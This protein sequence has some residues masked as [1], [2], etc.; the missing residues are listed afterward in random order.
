MTAGCT[1]SST[2]IHTW[3]SGGSAVVLDPEHSPKHCTRSRGGADDAVRGPLGSHAGRAGHVAH[4]RAG[5][6][7]SRGRLPVGL[8]QRQQGDPN[9]EAANQL[10]RD[11]MADLE[12]ALRAIA[13]AARC[14]DTRA[15]S[16]LFAGSIRGAHLG[17]PSEQSPDYLDGWDAP[18]RVVG[19]RRFV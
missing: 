2:P 6:P 15:V 12:L 3:R 7:A 9:R 5:A 18:V 16:M 1:T 19:E 14:E 8:G 13:D 11:A 10:V 17:A 4:A